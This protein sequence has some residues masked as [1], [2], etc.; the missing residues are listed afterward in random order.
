MQGYLNQI[1]CVFRSPNKI[2]SGDT[3]ISSLFKHT[4][5]RSQYVPPSLLSH[6][7]TLSN[8]CCPNHKYGFIVG[9]PF[10]LH[11]HSR[12]RD[13]VDPIGIIASFSSMRLDTQGESQVGGARTATREKYFYHLLSHTMVLNF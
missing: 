10:W 8:G 4:P 12:G 7:T 3:V 9:L 13:A 6:P 2:R 5:L 11:S 1:G